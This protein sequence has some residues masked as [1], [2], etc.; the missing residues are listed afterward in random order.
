MHIKRIQWLHLYWHQ[1]YQPE[2][3]VLYISCNM[4]TRD[5]PDMYTCSLRALGIHIGQITRAHVITI[6]CTADHSGSCPQ[7]FIKSR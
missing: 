2:T 4:G 6:K 5:L 1:G 7:T 3:E